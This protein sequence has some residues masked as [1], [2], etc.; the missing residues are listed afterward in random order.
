MEYYKAR[1]TTKLLEI[2]GTRVSPQPEPRVEHILNFGRVRDHPAKLKRGE[3][4]RC[5][6]NAARL[7]LKGS[8][9]SLAAI[10][11]GYALSD[12]G[13]WRP[14]SWLVHRT[15]T[16]Y[17]IIETTVLR[18]CYFGLAIKG[19]GADKWAGVMLGDEAEVNRCH[20]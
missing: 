13:M 1:L 8:P 14:H 2:G 16:G 6:H 5:H 20:Q 11:T 7:W 4:N 3:P 17:G 19:E 10:G 12:D 15:R 9:K 18:E